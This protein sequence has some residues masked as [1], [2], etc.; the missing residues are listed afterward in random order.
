MR[1]WVSRNVGQGT[2]RMFDPPQDLDYGESGA[3]CE[4]K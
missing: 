4:T 3:R 2:I 1:D